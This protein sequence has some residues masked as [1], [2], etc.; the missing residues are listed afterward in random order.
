[1]LEISQ[2]R[3]PD[4]SNRLV[5]IGR[6]GTGKTVGG[7]W[8]LSNFDL[9]RPWI[10]LNL[11]NDEHIESIEKARFL[12]DYSYVPKKKDSGLFVLT[13]HPRDLKG[14]LREM[15]PVDK[16][17][18]RVWERQRMGVFIDEAFPLGNSDAVNSILTQ[19]RSREI[20]VIACTQRPAWVSRYLFTEASFIQVYDLNDT[21]DIQ[22]IESFTPID[23]DSEPPLAEYCSYYYDVAR[24]HLFR[25]N[26]V[27]DMDKIRN[28]FDM[29]LKRQH[30]L[31]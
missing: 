13:V 24:D 3:L 8:H 16:Y 14:T 15:S 2:P 26:P 30:I 9:S 25:F 21:R 19:G 29:K 31:V 12:P 11:K 5:E 27:P 4:N 7:L 1:M 23:W 17:L 20:P 28:K 10:L 6:T 22:T 18:E